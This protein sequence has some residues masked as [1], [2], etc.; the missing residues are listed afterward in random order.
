M[1]RCLF[2]AFAA[3]FSTGAMEQI[4][5]KVTKEHNIEDLIVTARELKELIIQSKQKTRLS[6]LKI[7]QHKF[8]LVE[9]SFEKLKTCMRE[10]DEDEDKMRKLVD[11]ILVLMD[12]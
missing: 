9:L 5:D 10:V 8:G 7:L 1:N 11:H 12:S 2:L 6:F 3:F 4:P